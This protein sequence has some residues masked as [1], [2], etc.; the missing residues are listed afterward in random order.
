MYNVPTLRIKIEK[1]LY[2]IHNGQS[3]LISILDSSFSYWREFVM[4]THKN[5]LYNF[6]YYIGNTC[7]IKF[8]LKQTNSLTLNFIG[9]EI[10]N[11]DWRLRLQG[12]L[13]CLRSLL[14][15][16]YRAKIPRH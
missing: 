9:Q 3:K 15:A 2:T 13:F 1:N 7:E 11:K 8:K 14:V 4:H 6:I 16:N 5:I 12:L 10:E